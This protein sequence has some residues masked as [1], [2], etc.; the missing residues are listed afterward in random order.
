L[1]IAGKF[2][3]V[4]LQNSEHHSAKICGDGGL[5]GDVSNSKR[6]AMQY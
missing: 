1:L 4:D 3:F 6:D 2:R 5:P